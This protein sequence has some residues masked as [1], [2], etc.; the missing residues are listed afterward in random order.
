VFRTH[1]AGPLQMTVNLREYGA[2][3]GRR[4]IAPVYG[5]RLAESGVRNAEGWAEV[6][7]ALQA[8]LAADADLATQA[9]AA[10]AAVAVPDGGSAGGPGSSSSGGGASVGRGVWAASAAAD[11]PQQ[12]QALMSAASQRAVSVPALLSWL[13]ALASAP[14]ADA[15]VPSGR[16]R[17]G[18]TERLHGG[19]PGSEAGAAAGASRAAHAPGSARAAD[20][21]AAAGAAAARR[22][23]GGSSNPAQQQQQQPSLVF[24][25]NKSLA[26]SLGLPS[27]LILDPQVSALGNMSISSVSWVL[28]SLGIESLE[29]VPRL[30]HAYALQPL[31]ELLAGGGGLLELLR[32]VTGPAH[33]LYPSPDEVVAVPRVLLTLADEEGEEVEEEQ[34]GGEGGQ[35][36]S[37]GSSVARRQHRAPRASP[38]GR[39]NTEGEESPRDSLQLQPAL[40][41]IVTTSYEFRAAWLKQAAAAAT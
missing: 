14:K 17:R 5:Q 9:A 19:G 41:I 2:L 22:G 31:L 40:R 29:A 6:A 8:L 16:S 38:R 10:A 28:G 27:A 7:R 20:E 4:G 3:T 18:S 33:A 12:R 39:D 1:F 15:A 35:L 32:G 26:A 24:R 11:L 34:G 37:H 23:A 21:T 36:L 25:K 30:A 13:L